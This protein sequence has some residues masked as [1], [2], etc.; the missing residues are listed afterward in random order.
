MSL[1]FL[2]CSIAP[3]LD[4]S[5][6]QWLDRSIAQ[7]LGLL[8]GRSLDRLIA[9]RSIARSPS[10]TLAR[11]LPRLIA[12]SIAHPSVTA[13]IATQPQPA[14]KSIPTGQSKGN[15][16]STPTGSGHCNLDRLL[17]DDQLVVSVYEC[18]MPWSLLEESSPLEHM[19]EQK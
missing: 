4:P 17:A 10:R 12:H 5:I 6:A 11:S 9:R 3:S 15:Q 1:G 2:A 13:H 7:S 8:L 19:A 16:Q 14:R 18:L